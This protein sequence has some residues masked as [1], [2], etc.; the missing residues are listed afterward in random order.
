M[1]ALTGLS[2]TVP[3]GAQILPAGPIVFGGGRIAISGDVTAT[4]G[5]AHATGAQEDGG[6]C[7]DDLGFFNYT[8]YERSLLRLM[9][10]DVAAEVK[11][12]DWVSLLA[13][14]RS[15]NAL[16]KDPDFPTP[17]RA[18]AFYV[19]V[20]PWSGRDFDVQVG[21]VPPTFGAFARRTYASDNFLIGY[22]LAYQYLTSLR[23]DALPASAEE[24]LRM[25]G[26]GWESSF[27]VG[28]LEPKAGLPLVNALHWDTGLQV[29][30]GSPTS[31]IEA[32]ASLTNG[33]LANPLLREDNGGRQF[34]A[35]VEVHPAAG[36]HVGVSGASGPFVTR[37]ASVSAGTGGMTSRFTQTAY[38]ADVEY[39]RGYY[40]L[41]AETVL[42]EWR[43]P[44]VGDP[45]REW[46]LRALA[47]SV[48]GRYKIRPGL[49]AAARADHL[50][51]SEITAG[52]IRT[53]WEAPVTRLEVG[54]GYAL[55][56]NVL[57]KLSFQRN[58]RR[59]GRER[60]LNLTSAQIVYW[61]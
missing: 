32:T 40:V 42:S 22:P 6:V 52:A 3:A 30:T 54:G 35:R 49:Y 47:T 11:A 50:G 12:T 48:E 27:S 43:L 41:R 44:I 7:A 17:V 38:G 13:E 2:T 26:R 56:R 36:L 53:P 20:K 21:R 55:Q 4:F 34:G 46:P 29:H 15:E 8:D 45:N 1:F 39:S 33:T 24:L 9:R 18:Y 25:R 19:R 23:A 10:I 61:F 59:G 16:P 60:D 58:T 5:C 31:R 51:F 28:D 37:S 57:L 14:V